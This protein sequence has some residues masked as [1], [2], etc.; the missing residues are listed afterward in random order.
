MSEVQKLE[1]AATVELLDG[2]LTAVL[3]K[4]GI[5]LTNEQQAAMLWEGYLNF[6]SMCARQQQG[7]VEDIKI[8]WGPILKGKL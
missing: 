7:P 3:T 6:I 4:K 8:D 2:V 5:V 1:H